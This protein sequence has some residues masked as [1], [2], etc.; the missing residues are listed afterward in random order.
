[1]RARIPTMGYLASSCWT[2]YA[3]WNVITK[4][5]QQSTFTVIAPA[6]GYA[7][8]IRRL[9]IQQ[10]R[11]R[12]K[13]C[14]VCSLHD[15]NYANERWFALRDPIPARAGSLLAVLPGCFKALSKSLLPSILRGSL[16]RYGVY[17]TREVCL[18]SNG[19]AAAL[20]STIP[21]IVGYVST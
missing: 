14:C 18:G 3:Q 20:H 10:H 16:V 19:N 13:L 4:Q 17:R 7:C 1:M 21:L 6:F 9:C 15:G 8:A 2:D 12:R 11:L 5:H